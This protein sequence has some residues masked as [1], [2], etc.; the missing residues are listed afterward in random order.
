MSVIKEYRLDAWKS[1]Y[2]TFF[3]VQGESESRTFEIQLLNSVSPINLTDRTVFFFAKKPDDTVVHFSCVVY[4]A[5]GGII[6]FEAPGELSAVSGKFPCWIQIIDNNGSDLRFDGM[7]VSVEE[8]SANE[9]LNSRDY[10]KEFS[11]RVMRLDEILED[12]LTA[13][14][15]TRRSEEAARL[16][17]EAASRADQSESNVQEAWMAITSPEAQVDASSNLPVSGSA[18]AAYSQK[19]IN[20]STV[21]LEAGVSEL[22]DGEVYLVYE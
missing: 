10:L 12:L 14:E 13:S 11:D 19:K 22:A 6:H 15:A 16:S 7:T 18:V 8:C 5:L 3:L 17:Q 20:F 21:D 1:N 2:V 9:D 4:D